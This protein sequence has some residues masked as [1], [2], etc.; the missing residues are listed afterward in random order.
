MAYNPGIEP[1]NNAALG[2]VVGGFQ[3][4]GAG[5]SDEIKKRKQ[6]EEQNA[7]N[8]M[9]FQTLKQ[10][11]GP[12]GQLLLSED[13][14]QKFLSGNINAQ[15][16]IVTAAGAR[17][18]Q[19]FQ[20]RQQQDQMEKARMESQLTQ[21]MLAKSNQ[22]ITITGPDGQ[23]YQAGVYG[24]RGEPHF[25]PS[26]GRFSQ[27]AFKPAPEVLNQ[28]KDAG[29]TFA[30][31]SDKGGRWINTTGNKPDLGPDGNPIISPDG[32]SFISGGKVRPLT[33]SMIDQRE[34]YQQKLEDAKKAAGP[35][36]YD[37]FIPD[38]LKSKPTPSPAPSAQPASG[39]AAPT[40]SS[41]P[42]RVNTVEEANA[43]PSGTMF[44]TP[45]GR[46]KKKP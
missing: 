7:F 19:T 21:N 36:W 10:A 27:P 8:Q 45:D 13:E 31:T 44:L 16:G 12:D 23:P 20:N 11:K 2:A 6:L 46:L 41:T 15:N 42:V 4:L 32:T 40:L 33:Q 26:A 38:A 37:N 9:A 3:Q 28:M 14:Q 18:M 29:Y 1:N 43:L 22:P 5:I 30:P 39:P 34:K 24:P 25:L 35:H 17:L